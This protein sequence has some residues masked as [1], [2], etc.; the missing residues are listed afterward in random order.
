MQTLMV[1]EAFSKLDSAPSHVADAVLEGKLQSK[2]DAIY[3][4]DSSHFSIK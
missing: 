1:E 4:D 2:K 3:S